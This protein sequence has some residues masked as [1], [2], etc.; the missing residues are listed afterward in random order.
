MLC[1]LIFVMDHDVAVVT[2]K[3]LNIMIRTVTTLE[4]S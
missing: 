2:M 4:L 1:L 3:G